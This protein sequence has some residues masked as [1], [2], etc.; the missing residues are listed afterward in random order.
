M[1]LKANLGRLE[2]R[3]NC[4]ELAKEQDTGAGVYILYN[5]VHGSSRNRKRI[6]KGETEKSY[7]RVL[8]NGRKRD[9]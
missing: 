4:V 6:S 1:G 8:T 2:T 7:K 9:R 5:G 3:L